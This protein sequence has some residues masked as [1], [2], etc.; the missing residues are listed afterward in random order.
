LSILPLRFG[1]D[2]E[3]PLRECGSKFLALENDDMETD[4]EI[5]LAESN[6]LRQ[7]LLELTDAL[8]KRGAL[9][10]HEI[11]GA[12]LRAEWGAEVLDDVAEEAGDITRHHAQIAKLTTDAWGERFGLKPSLYTLRKLHMQWLSEGQPGPPPLD[13]KEVLDAQREDD[14]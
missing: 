14:E 5:A 11:A 7:L 8:L 12:L 2:N 6:V 1:I 4:T 9:S 3:D 10:E 13:T